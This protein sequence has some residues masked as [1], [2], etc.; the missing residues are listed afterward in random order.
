MSAT[1]RKP[2]LGDGQKADLGPFEATAKRPRA[3]LYLWPAQTR[4]TTIEIPWPTPMH[5]VARP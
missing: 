5:M 1:A 3:I 4:S 2:E